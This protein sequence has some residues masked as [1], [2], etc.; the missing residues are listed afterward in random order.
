MDTGQ[1]Y[2]EIVLLDMEKELGTV[3]SQASK[4]VQKKLD[5]YLLK[6]EAKDIAK[7]ELLTKGEITEAEYKQWRTGQVMISKRWEEME[8]VLSRD[9]TN[10]N[11]I[12]SSIIN[13]HTPEAY[14]IGMNYGTFTVEKGS[15]LNTSF[16]LYDR[17]TVERLMRDDPDL[18]P[19]AS[20]NIPKDRRWNKQHI[21]SAV[22]QGVLQGEDI[23]T[24]SKR[25]QSVTDMNRNSAIRNARTMM[26]SAENG[27]RMDSYR[28]AE[29]MGIKVEKQWLAT[30]DG[31]T[32]HSHAA[33][34][35]EHVPLDE[36]FANGLMFPGDMDGD[37]REVYNCRCTMVALVEDAEGSELPLDIDLEDMDYEDWLDE[38]EGG[39]DVVEGIDI[40]G[41]W[42][43]RESEFDFEIEDVINAQGFDGL[44]KVVKADEFDKYVKDSNLLMERG[45]TAPTQEALDLYKKELREGKFYVDTRKEDIDAWG[46]G[47]YTTP[48][49]SGIEDDRM[50]RISYEFYGKGRGKNPYGSVDI[51]TMTKDANIVDYDDIRKQYDEYKKEI[52]NT[53]NPISDK[54]RYEKS[55]FDKY[56]GKLSQNNEEKANVFFNF[57]M[58][59]GKTSF[60]E[61]SD[62]Y[63]VLTDND[64]KVIKEMVKEANS[65]SLMNEFSKKNDGLKYEFN[66]IGAFTAARGYDAISLKE[67]ALGTPELIV[68]NRTKLIIKGE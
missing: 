18:L 59:N 34:D 39:F 37:P 25:L 44:P 29:R 4:D 13:D 61:A 1:K 43:R 46:G 57:Q 47:M 58:G 23:R 32:R 65:P 3:Y 28:R 67:G 51:M 19:K 50:H 35:G 63:S 52:V 17:N 33:Q 21:N 5:N 6:F 54:E 40:T 48:N 66:D 60:D 49:F 64:K 45:Y 14:A 62:A 41:T 26:T 2:T 27:G 68:F 7:Q 16:S 11:V 8:E 22:L 53:K 20:I 38:H 55:V 36:E 42:T 56:K 24:V 15:L 10:A 9:M 30:P 12:A 31:R